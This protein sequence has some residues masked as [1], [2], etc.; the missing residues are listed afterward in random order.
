MAHARQARQAR[1]AVFAMQRQLRLERV[2][3]LLTR[4]QS[5]LDYRRQLLED[6]ARNLERVG[7]FVE[8]LRKEQQLTHDARAEDSDESAGEQ[9]Q[10][11][12]D[13]PRPGR[14]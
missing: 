3:G 13:D 1:D 8:G 14:S 11:S 4:R 10:R 7:Q 5:A 12:D 6:Q 2:R 9:R